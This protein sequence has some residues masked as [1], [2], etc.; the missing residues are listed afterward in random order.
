[1]PTLDGCEATQAAMS[2]KSKGKRR[3]E[4]AAAPPLAKDEE[5]DEE[6][7]F[8][9]EFGDDYDEEECV[10]AG[11]DEA[12]EEAGEPTGL[13][14]ADA[15]GGDG[16]HAEVD[17]ALYRAGDAIPQGERLDYDS[18]AYDM[19]HRLHLE[20]PCLS[21][22][23]LRDSLGEQRTTFPMTAYAVA[24]TQAERSDQNQ[25]VCAKFSQLAKTRHDEDSD[26]D[27]DSE[28]G[29]DDDPLVESQLVSHPGTVNRL[30][31]MPQR[32]TMCAT[33][34]D[35]GKVH[36]FD[37]S[38]PF[39]NLHAPGSA[40]AAPRGPVFSFGGHAEEGYALGFSAAKAGLLASGDNAS[41][42]HVWQP[43]E[44]GWAVDSEA[45]RGH[46][47]AVEDVAWSPVE[48]N[49]L[50][51]CGCDSTVRVWDVRKKSGSAL[52]VDEGHGVDVNVL[53]WNTLVNYLVVTGADDGSFRVWDL[54]S[55]QGGE[56]VAR[57]TWHHA[58][59][60]SVEWSPNESST[61]AVCGSDNQ[62]TLWD[63]AL[64]DDPEAQA[65]HVGRD[66]L[67]NIPPQLYF[68]H[69]GQSEPKELHWHAQM[70]GVI[71]CTAEDSFHIFKPA[72][73]ADGAAD[74]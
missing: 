37:L 12:M 28:D 9:D 30:C 42:V 13:S 5:E 8:E 44:G 70:P 65:A 63:L 14:A 6:L 26:S 2:A 11:D 58:P 23:F 48:A 24:G 53:S 61:L 54:R 55:F 68:V 73:A 36:I 59:I 3:A 71:G 41:R 32:P 64:E 18:T 50:M 35:T 20:W 33:W 46:T 56:P 15:L 40:A 19:L 52:T 57:F 67:R 62:L 51:S 34:A 27:D 47:G 25:L 4:V 21:F 74:E 72:N 22:S 69:Q 38:A 60:T 1:M 29:D 10:N 49:V 43:T 31:L 39:A 45:Y 17:G 16:V 66:D 7:E